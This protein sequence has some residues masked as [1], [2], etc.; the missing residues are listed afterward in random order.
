MDRYKAKK[1]FIQYQLWQDCRNGCKFCSEGNQKIIDKEWSLT[2]VLDKLSDP[3]VLDYDDMGVIGGEIFDNQLENP[4]VKELFY[5]IFEKSST[6][7]FDKI[8][9]ATNLLYDMNDYLIPFL[10]YLKELGI[11]HKILLCTSYDLKYR[12]HTESRRKLWEDNMKWLHTNYPEL[13]THVEIILT[14]FFI[15]AVLA[16]EFS[17]TDFQN[18]FHTR[19]D[20]IDPSS[21][22]MYN[23]KK[24]CETNVPGFFPTKKSYIK[25]LI[26]KGIK[27]KEI[28]LSCMISYQL[29]ANKIYHL[30]QG[31]Y[32][33]YNDRREP[34]FRVKCSDSTKKYELGLIDSDETM[35]DIAISICNMVEW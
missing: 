12:F 27:S 16:N 20:Y 9:V 4:T 7:H 26:E 8:C 10:N 19:I 17:I 15:D 35:E 14:Q 13:Q 25:F 24:E 28:D 6:M 34:G 1:K 23:D 21:G 29:R 30:D 31:E 18:E 22:M 11:L 33:I 5:K 32:V 3:E 2:Y